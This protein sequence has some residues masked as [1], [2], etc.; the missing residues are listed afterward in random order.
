MLRF[1]QN[2]HFFRGG[3][4]EKLKKRERERESEGGRQ[5]G[6]QSGRK[7]EREREKLR[8]GVVIIYT[9][10]EQQLDDINGAAMA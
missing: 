9:L 3:S 7:R 5:A 4:E 10:L 2:I 6:R 8:A 1:P